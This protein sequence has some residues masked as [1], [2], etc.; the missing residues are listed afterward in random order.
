MLVLKRLVVAALAASVAGCGQCGGSSSS[1]AA[2]GPAKAVAEPEVPAPEGLIG[3][4]WIRGPD[5]F[6]SKIQN[7]AS[8]A[9]ALLPPTAGELACAAAGLDSRAAPLVD[10]KSTSYAVLAD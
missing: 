7:G 10:G 4:A 5:A 2:A 1:G 9:I 8:G 6:W 3:Q